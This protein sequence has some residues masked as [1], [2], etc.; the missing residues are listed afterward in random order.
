MSISDHRRRRTK[1]SP[2]QAVAGNG[3]LDRRALLGRGVVFAGAM[4]T[5]ALCS[6]TGAAAEPLKDAPLTLE[7]GATI[8]PYERPSRF[9][10][11]VVRT[12]SNPNGQPSASAA[13]T[14]HHLVNGT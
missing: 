6:L 8:E 3:L 12:V 5:G 1:S 2:L 11:T 7:P 14:P 10:K 13:K 4:S 9:E